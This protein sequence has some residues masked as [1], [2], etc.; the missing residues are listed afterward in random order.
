MSLG[1]AVRRV[2]GPLEG[3]LSRTYRAVFLDVS[4]LGEELVSFDFGPRVL[5]VG[6]GDGLVAAQIVG[7]RP[8]VRLLGIDLID[9]PGRHFDADRSRVEFRTWSTSAL[10]AERPEPF[11]AVVLADVLHHVPPA[12]RSAL[13]ADVEA[14][15]APG[16]VLLVKET[17]VTSSPGY[18]MGHLAD[19]WISGDRAV[20]FLP[21]AAIVD[22]VT[23]SIP[24]VDPIGRA[25][26]R[27]WS[28][29]LLLVWRRRAEPV[30]E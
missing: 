6:V 16:G 17:V 9:S 5:E 19:R 22:L 7:R 21:E 4:S 20:S 2:L 29:N 8:D 15:L 26:I 13:L 30:E 11:D 3:P 18:W 25:T 28:T 23:S 24:D 10:L 14:L 27:P 1:P 12:D